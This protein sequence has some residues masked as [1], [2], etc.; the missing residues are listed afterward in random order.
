MSRTRWQPAVWGLASVWGVAEAGLGGVMHGLK[1]PFTGLTV[2]GVAVAVLIVLAA[3]ERGLYGTSP[4]SKRSTRL[5]LEVTA[6]ILLIKALA[7]PHSPV[8]AYVAVAFQGVVA[9]LLFRMVPSFRWAAVLFALLA[10]IESATQKLLM[11]VLVY[12][13]AF[14]DALDALTGYASGQIAATGLQLPLS[15][16]ILLGLFLALYSGWG[17]LLGATVGRWPERA[18]TL[19]AELAVA[20]RN[21]EFEE[22]AEVA[23]RKK[24]RGGWGV[25]FVLVAVL[26]AA[27]A[28]WN[29]LGWLVVRT[30]V[31]TGVLF[32]GV[33]PLVRW[34]VERRA[35]AARRGLALQLIATFSEQ[36]RRFQ[37]AFLRARRLHPVWRMPLVGLEHWI[38]LNLVLPP[39]AD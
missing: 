25:L 32:W 28:G 2:G 3:H 16:S 18:Q 34:A 21:S 35:S 27:G 13:H 38:L 20:W 14:I 1:L 19:G 22:P 29:E 37:W 6:T 17:L 8:T 30:V 33:G 36:R 5:L 23:E 39:D 9:A 4:S 11:M 15:S 31:I 7:S 24:R 12:G 26:A 10:M